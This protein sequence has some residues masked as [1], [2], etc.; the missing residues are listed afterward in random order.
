MRV[1]VDR[2]RCQGHNRCYME[3]PEVYKIDEE[4][5]SHVEHEEVPPELERR[6]RRAAET[7]P[8]GA[9]EVFD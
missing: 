1:R 6:A 4:G 2:G 9:I 5:F 8:E 7:C 3:C